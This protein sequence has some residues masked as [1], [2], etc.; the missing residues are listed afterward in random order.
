MGYVIDTVAPNVPS[1]SVN[2]DSP[3]SVD[4]PQI[5]FSALDNVAVDHF[6]ITYN[7]D[8]ATP[9]TIGSST[10]IDPATSPLILNLD[11]DELLHTVTVTV[12]DAA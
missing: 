9:V 4:A 8:D 1:I 3:F 7:I 10:V 12:F 6:T 2:T 5:T 11:P